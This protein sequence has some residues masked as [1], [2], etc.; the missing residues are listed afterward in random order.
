M[1]CSTCHGHHF[2]VRNSQMIPCPECGGLGEIHCCDGLTAQPDS[3]RG[4]C[5]SVHTPRYE[6]DTSHQVISHSD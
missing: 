6:A 4:P 5:T 3:P 1:L 2:I